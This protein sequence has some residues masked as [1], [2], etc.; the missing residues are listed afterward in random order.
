MPAN[1]ASGGVT[2]VNARDQVAR[3]AEAIRDDDSPFS[4][5]LNPVRVRLIR[6]DGILLERQGCRGQEGW[7]KVASEV[8][9]HFLGRK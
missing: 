1:A 9:S 2:Q 8:A 4:G 3:L 7:P 6:T 5:C